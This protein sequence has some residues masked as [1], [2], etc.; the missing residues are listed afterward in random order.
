MKK[1]IRPVL[2]AAIGGVLGYSYYY[3]VGCSNGG[4]CPLTSRW[5]ITTLYG[6]IAGVLMALPNKTNKKTKQDIGSNEG[7]E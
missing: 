4:S 2:Y 3:F 7:S 1:F 6:L 5:Y